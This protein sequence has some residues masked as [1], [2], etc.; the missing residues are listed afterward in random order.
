MQ[1]IFHLLA[2]VM[3]LNIEDED[4]MLETCHSLFG[5]LG[6]DDIRY[7][8]KQKNIFGISPAVWASFMNAY[9]L[10]MAILNYPGVYLVRELQE[11]TVVHR[12]Y[13]VTEF[14]DKINPDKN[15]SLCYSLMFLEKCML[16]H[17]SASDVFSSEFFK[18][19]IKT[20][21][22]VNRFF[23][24][25][26]VLLRIHFLICILAYSLFGRWAYSG[27]LQ[28]DT[29]YNETSCKY[30]SSYFEQ[31]V[32]MLFTDTTAKYLAIYILATCS[33]MLFTDLVD[34]IL[35]LK[36]SF[37]WSA[38]FGSY[39]MR[40]EYVVQYR[41]Y[42][43]QHVVCLI[44]FLLLFIN[45]MFAYSCRE[46]FLGV[47]FEHILYIYIMAFSI[48]SILMFCQLSESFGWFV[49]VIQRLTLD[50]YPFLV[51]IMFLAFPIAIVH[52]RYAT[53]YP[54]L[55]QG[56]FRSLA[57]S[58][59]STFL[60]FI[61]QS[62]YS[63]YKPTYYLVFG[64]IQ[65]F[66]ILLSLLCLNF[67]IAI[68]SDTVARVMRNRHKM[69]TVQKIFVLQT[70]EKRFRNIPFMQKLYSKLNKRYFEHSDGKILFKVSTLR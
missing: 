39:F 69:C 8:F 54:N 50:M 16:E 68:F 22:K 11:G 5:L 19:Y 31:T 48:F 67:L 33:V 64:I 26:W 15:F 20:K 2:I 45:E 40:N 51:I 49:V 14:E 57:A 27:I 41:L 66:S 63:S 21:I 52:L 32:G 23:M 29:G 60:I 10:C 58:L 12:W 4:K 17:P 28:I 59:Y 13:D 34:F 25:C 38:A 47:V 18:S 1:N 3:A 24:I 30:G 7:L 42:K 6:E 65:L 55:G 35:F 53:M 61:G 62:E 44:T 43:A 46:P 36:Q 9:K 70:T 37:K 56:E